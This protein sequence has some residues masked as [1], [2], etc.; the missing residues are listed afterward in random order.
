MK[1]FQFTKMQGL[2]NDFVV[3]EGPF[4]LSPGEIRVIC[5]RRIGIGGDGLLVVTHAD[6]VRME[7]WNADGS[8]AEMC[9]NGLRCVARYAYDRGW[10]PHRSFAVQTPIG[11]RSVRVLDDG[12]EGEMGRPRLDGVRTIDGADYEIV[13][14]GN[15]HAITWVEEPG[16]VDV[17]HGALRALE[18]QVLASAVRVI[19]SARHVG[20]QRRD[21]RRQGQGFVKNR[22]PIQFRLL[23]IVLQHEIMKVEK[24]AQLLGKALGVEQILQP[25]GAARDL[26]LV[27]RADAAPGGADLAAAFR[28]L[29][30]VV[31]RRVI[32]KNQL[33]GLAD[34]QSVHHAAHSVLL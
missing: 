33:A 31:E 19:E 17:E 28:R 4:R 16:D 23:V 3:V 7:Y 25:D 8:P 29:A 12:V 9:G 18:Q 27:G 30:R 21:P 32:R 14:L 22:L 24:L 15:P 20:D 26:V 2:G 13:D 5:D 1:A 34:G 6:P 11:M 10:A